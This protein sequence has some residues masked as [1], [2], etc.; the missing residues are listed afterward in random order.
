MAQLSERPFPP[1][2]Y[3]VVVVG[4]GPG[5]LQTSYCLTRLG[6]P[7][8]LLSQDDAP[9]GMFRRFPFF[10]R[11]VT[12][13]KPH[14]PVE[15]GVRF[16]EWYDWNSLLSDDPAQ[17]GSVIEFMDGTSY[18]PARPEME[19]G[20]VA[21]AERTG[22]VARYG[23][24]WESTARTDDGFVLT[25]SDGEYRCKTVVFAIGMTEPW[26]PDIDGIDL[27]PHYVE[28][29]PAKEFAD[30]RV[31]IMGK[32]NS[33]FELA[34]GLLPWAKQLILGSPRPA[35][36]SIVIHSTS[37]ARARYMQP[38]EDNA[39]GGG[40]L[41][42]DA[43]IERIEKTATGFRVH[44]NGTTR[45]GVMIFDVDEVIAGTGFTTPMGDLP[46][47]GVKTFYQN[48]L[49]AQTP[50][51][52]SA[53]VPGV[54]FAGSVTQGSIGL[55]KYGIP[56][57]SAA[58]HGFRYNARVLARH[59][60]ETRH[61]VTTE[62]PLVERDRVVPYLLDEATHAPELWNQQ[63][64][65]ARVL[66]V[67]PGRGITDE[68]ILPLQHFVDAGGPDA[69]AI[70]METDGTGE[71]HPALYVRK[72][73]STSEHVLPPNALLDFTTSEH[74]AEL[75]NVLKPLID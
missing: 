57:N 33:G 61:G 18:F 9:A 21:F 48:R 7:H 34:D 37:G 75:T 67:D 24:R 43:A 56:S 47:L 42:I 31:F 63:S 26:K 49:P 12:W 19:K 58:V 65:L 15:K 3:P 55:K 40:H 30:K 27:V 16:H 60:A 39:L 70:T 46:A 71:M 25:T 35:K 1:G 10:Q 52:E 51:W 36:L 5:G 22:I 69:V 72:D 4:T 45:P 64:Y 17:R 41:V 53:T 62:R 14:A 73:G 66:H 23:C 20:L 54:F 50:F 29:K 11:L 38:Y 68:G 44:T 28:M 2:E 8:A 32:R 13:S 74:H 59:I 6:V